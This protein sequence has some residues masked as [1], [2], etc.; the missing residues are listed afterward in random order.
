MPDSIITETTGYSKDRDTTDA[1]YFVHKSNL[2]TPFTVLAQKVYCRQRNGDCSLPPSAIK[3]ATT[4]DGL[5]RQGEGRVVLRTQEGY[6]GCDG[7]SRFYGELIGMAKRVLSEQDL[8]FTET[9]IHV[10][11]WAGK[12]D[13][14]P[15]LLKNSV[16]TKQWLG[17]VEFQSGE[18]S[19][20]G[21][22]ALNIKVSHSHARR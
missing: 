21:F 6:K 18:C 17:K 22:L 7:W 19:G 5:S 10:C 16:P 2:T 11:C 3:P 15:I 8:P 9:F 20:I 13:N 12:G 14:R 1:T 4:L